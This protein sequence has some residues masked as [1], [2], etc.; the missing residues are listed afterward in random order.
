MDK[1]DEKWETLVR[2]LH[3][4]APKVSL[5]LL[6]H[7]ARSTGLDP[8]QRQLY[9][10]NRGG[11]WQVQ[12]SIDGFRTVASRSATYA[13]QAGPFWTTG[14]DAPWSDIPPD[15][16]PYAAKVGVRLTTCSEPTWG[17]AKYKDYASG[18]MWTKFASTMNAK[19]AEALALRKALPGEFSGLYTAEEMDQAGANELAAPVSERKAWA[20]AMATEPLDR[21]AG[22]TVPELQLYLGE[23]RT[24]RNTDEATANAC[25]DV[26]ARRGLVKPRG[27]A[28]TQ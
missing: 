13:G 7:T 8:L 23:L 9:L 10:I 2:E 15:G 11:K 3:P 16:V 27:A 20:K 25:Y 12:T 24:L 21:A 28:G 22:I 17:V 26:L 4:G 19:V 14:P 18:P 6:L 5:D 1:F